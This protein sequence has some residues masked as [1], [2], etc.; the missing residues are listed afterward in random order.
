MTNIEVTVN[1]SRWPELTLVVKVGTRVIK[2]SA[3]FDQAA[4]QFG[5][6]LQDLFKQVVQIQLQKKGQQ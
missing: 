6:V 2:A 3:R 5:T 1:E 4:Q